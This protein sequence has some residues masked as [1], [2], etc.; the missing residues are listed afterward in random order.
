MFSQPNAKPFSKTGVQPTSQ[1][2]IVGLAH[3]DRGSTTLASYPG[4]G[5]LTAPVTDRCD[6]VLAFL[7]PGQLTGDSVFAALSARE[8]Q[9]LAL[10]ADSLSNADIAEQLQISEKT[11]R[12][13]ASNLFDKLGVW[14][15]AQAIVFARERATRAEPPTS[16]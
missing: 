1:A 15:R 14:S 6:D 5:R 7:Q 9:V 2:V 16:P 3:L 11:V 4:S 13:H 10:M 12:N 8:R